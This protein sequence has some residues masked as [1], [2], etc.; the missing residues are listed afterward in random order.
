MSCNYY[1]EGTGFCEIAK[2][3]CKEVVICSEAGVWVDT[4]DLEE[5]K[6]E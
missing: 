2:I 5:T 4:K 1:N 3:P 6:H